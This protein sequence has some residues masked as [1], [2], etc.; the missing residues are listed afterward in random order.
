MKFI[1][2]NDGYLNLDSVVY[3]YPDE[4]SIALNNGN[5]IVIS[6]DEMEQLIELIED[7]EVI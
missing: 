1:R 3:I 6:G 4:N 7:G 2:V 5:Y